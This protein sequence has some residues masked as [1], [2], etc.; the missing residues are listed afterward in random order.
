MT[1][2]SEQLIETDI[3]AYLAQHEHKQLLRFLTCG[4]VDDGKSTL[5][6]RLLHD[7]KSIY[8]DQLAALRQDSAK[9]GTTGDDF[10]PALLMDGLQA[11]REQGITID[12]A[13]RYFS[14]TRRK[15]IIADT[16][17]H[18]QYTRN[19]AT[20]ASTS[21]LAVILVDA[22]NGVQTQTR[23]HSFIVSLLGIRRV[24][25]AIN[26]MD[27]VDYR[28]DVYERIR[29]DYLAF[30]G[31]LPPGDIRF[32]PLSALKGDNVVNRSAHLAWFDG[33]PLLELLDTID[34]GVDQNL[35][36]LRLPVQ[37]VNRPN[38][39]FRGYCGTLAAGTLKKGDPIQ[40][41]PSGKTSHVKSIVTYDGEL[42]E[43]SY[44]Q[45]ITVTLTDEIDI[46][47]GDLLVRTDQVPPLLDSR[48][49]AHIVWM[50]ETALTRG[51][52]YYFKHATR[53]LTG[54]IAEIQYRIDVNTLEQFDAEQ[55][56]LNEI[57]LC[58]VVLN[59]PL[60]FDAYTCCKETGAFIVIDRLS[61]ITVGAGMIVGAANRRDRVFHPVGAEE[62]A[63]RLNQRAITLWLT[64]NGAADIA[65]PLE[66]RL[67]ERGYSCYLL[68][69]SLVREQA[70][71][72][73]Q[74]LNQ[75]GLVVI[76]AVAGDVPDADERNIVLDA[77]YIDMARITELL[78]PFAGTTVAD[79][80]FI[81]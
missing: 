9:F 81:I 3:L 25:V 21:D 34:I 13:Y 12:V 60:I 18:E 1:R 51:K 32:I 26:K 23:R 61:N 78:S 6:G 31:Q 74:Q 20:G 54:A 10:D 36:D 53:T 7:T 14:T 70:F 71:M 39:D 63:A 59:A 52:Q 66:R 27:L 45:A 75:A 62:R 58:E 37:Y 22:R 11:E 46:S 50:T 47:R 35:S 48:F 67:F 19:M 69:N 29:S 57:G 43:A 76:G 44:P 77:E 5:I 64:G 55:L 40:V 8:E 42:E 17:G 24:V 38:L 49:I 79:K 80:D 4:S 41:L 16:P 28:Q 68:D 2:P 56:Q 72:V 73:A 33:A 65:A 15:F 30:A